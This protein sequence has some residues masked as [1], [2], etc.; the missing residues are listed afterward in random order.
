MTVDKS[1]QRVRHMFAEIAASYDRMNHLL[2]MCSSIWVNHFP[3]FRL[4]PVR[5]IM[6]ATLQ[7]SL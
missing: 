7:P 5:T 6:N 3:A 2:S 4:N 1:Q